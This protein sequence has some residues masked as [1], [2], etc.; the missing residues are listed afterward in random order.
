MYEL[1][2][3]IKF[4]IFVVN[5]GLYTLMSSDMQLFY[6][7]F[8]KPKSKT[9]QPIVIYMLIASTAHL[10]KTVVSS[11]IGTYVKGEDVLP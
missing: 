2:Y 8:L 5:E 9:M 10:D 4:T 3:L 7:F 1:H 11:G 6:T